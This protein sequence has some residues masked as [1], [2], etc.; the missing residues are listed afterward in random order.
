MKKV[1]VVYDFYVNCFFFLLPFFI[2]SLF[3]DVPSSQRNQTSLNTS[4]IVKMCEQ[5]ISLQQRFRLKTVRD[6]CETKISIL[7]PWYLHVY[8]SL[9]KCTTKLA[10][11]NSEDD[12]NLLSLDAVVSERI[13]P[14][15]PS[16]EEYPGKSETEWLYKLNRQGF[17]G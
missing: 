9:L 16:G 10:K 1:V 14:T 12:I 2:L 3:S 7:A 4:G 6:K 8:I 15:Y 17:N 13:K 5:N 11:W